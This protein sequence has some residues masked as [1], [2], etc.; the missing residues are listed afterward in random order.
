[1]NLR[2]Q[3]QMQS[4]TL[5]AIIHLNR[6]N[7]PLNSDNHSF[8]TASGGFA[9]T[10]TGHYLFA[11]ISTPTQRCARVI[12]SFAL[13]ERLFVHG[14]RTHALTHSLTH[15]HIHTHSHTH[16]RTNARSHPHSLAHAPLAARRG[17]PETLG[18]NKLP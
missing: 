5:N 6:P 14:Y 7:A 9:K 15:S 11:G 8:F 2:A 3:R 17:V 10:V 13:G 18:R 12:A 16:E 4:S 1:M